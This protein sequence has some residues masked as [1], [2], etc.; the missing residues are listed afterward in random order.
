M[1]YEK[2]SLIKVAKLYYYEDKTHQEIADMLGAS[3][4]SITRMLQAALAHGIVRIDVVDDDEKEMRSLEH[5]LEAQFGLKKV[6]LTKNDTANTNLRNIALAKKAARYINLSVQDGDIVGVGWGAAVTGAVEQMTAIK[7]KNTVVVPVI[8][9]VN[10]KGNIYH[11]NEIAQMASE[12][13]DCRHYK[14]YAPAVVYTRT[15]REVLMSD[16]AISSVCG[17]WSKLDVLVVGIGALKDA[18]PETVTQYLEKNPIGFDELGV[19]GEVCYNFIDAKGGK[20]STPMDDYLIHISREEIQKCPL[21][22]AIAWGDAKVKAIRS[23]LKSGMVDAL[24]T[25]EE[26]ASQILAM[27]D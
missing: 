21:T 11:V 13:M 15:T 20:V 10:E 25:H 17:Y 12:K 22:V 23:A 27:D 9:G 2:Q 4:V 6:L 3:R 14:L 5:R 16:D 1:A 8:G 7:K 24:I 26:T 18:M 19:S